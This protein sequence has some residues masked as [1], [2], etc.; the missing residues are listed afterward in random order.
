MVL[1]ASAIHRPDPADILQAVA[2]GIIVVDTDGLVSYLNRAGERLCGVSALTAQGQ[3][4]REVLGS[5]ACDI[6]CPLER[7][8]RTREVQQ[9]RDV[10]FIR[11]QGR[12]VVPVKISV[13]PLEGAG[14]RLSGGVIAVRTHQLHQMLGREKGRRWSDFVGESPS[15]LR[16]FE[17]LKVVAPSPVT[18]LIEGPT[19]TGKDLLAEIIHQNS[20]RADNSLVKV[21][22]AALP[23]NLLESELFGYVRGAFTGAERDKPGRFQLADGGTIF[24]DEISE[25]PLA[26]QAKLLRVLEDREFF[27]LG[28]RKTTTVDVRILAA[29][30]RALHRQVEA[31]LFRADLFYRLNVIR[32]AVPPLKER[33]QDLPDL[34]RRFIQRKN[35]E[36]G[37]YICRFSPPALE[38][39]LNYDYPGNV[40]E[41]EN[42]LE[43]ACLLC[44]G[45]VIKEDHLPW[46]L[47]E[48]SRP[49]RPAAA[50]P[51]LE[52]EEPEEKLLLLA[53]LEKH[54]WKRAAAARALG[55]D[56]TTLWRRM[57]RW[58]ITAP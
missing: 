54:R 20:P 41:L 50:A 53:A 18:V 30:N 52:E 36:R 55:L 42:I 17:V 57:K 49:A 13:T 35:V 44:Q 24:L 33:R 28:A 23:E 5:S 22:C 15:V 38:L 32:L 19:G 1:P 26:L 40:R 4:C 6:D 7:A 14:G 11:Q 39:L 31:G 9:D 3:P 45:D 43:H 46:S 8:L 27:P 29:T 47:L 51:P 21:N 56:R 2:L 12:S 48:D 25:L 37:T 16:I 58:G 34:I 10:V